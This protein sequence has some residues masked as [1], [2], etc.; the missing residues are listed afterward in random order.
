MKNTMKILTFILICMSWTLMYTSCKPKMKPCPACTSIVASDGP[1]YLAA[2]PDVV[3]LDVRTAEEVAD[4]K[5]EGSIHIDVKSEAFMARVA[6]LDKSKT[7]MV[8]CHS[9]IRSANAI[10]MMIGAGFEK[11]INVDGGY[12]EWPK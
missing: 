1:S 4:G 9:G 3:L 6:E 8:H 2:H 12:S 7:Y 11:L 5:I 10:N